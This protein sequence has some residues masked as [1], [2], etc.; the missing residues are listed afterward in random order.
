MNTSIKDHLKSS[1]RSPQPQALRRLRDG[2]EQGA[3]GAPATVFV[4]APTPSA[5]VEETMRTR[6]VRW[7]VAELGSDGFSYP[8]VI[9]SNL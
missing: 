1:N 5:K 6:C 3:Q 2:S 4:T 8:L 9:Y 7:G